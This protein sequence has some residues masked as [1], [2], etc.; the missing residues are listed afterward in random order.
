LGTK[1][2]KTNE[3]GEREEDEKSERVAYKGETERSREGNKGKETETILGGNN[4]RIT[5]RRPQGEEKV[6]RGSG[7]EKGGP[8]ERQ[9]KKREARGKRGSP[10]TKSELGRRGTERVLKEGKVSG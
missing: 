5:E 3:G 9:S 1:A 6:I 4:K 2:T 7:G 10:V 8:R